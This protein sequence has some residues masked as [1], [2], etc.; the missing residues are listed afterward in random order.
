MEK[1]LCVHLD[2]PKRN[3]PDIIWKN[4]D[5]AQIEAIVQEIEREKEA[6]KLKP[7]YARLFLCSN[8]S[9]AEAERKRT[10][11][12]ATAAGQASMTSRTTGDS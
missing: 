4:L 11:L 5:L 1:W 3:D 7:W 12:A 8:F 6:G 9:F 2:I 10:R